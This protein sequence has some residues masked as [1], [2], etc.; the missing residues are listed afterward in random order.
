MTIRGIIDRFASAGGRGSRL[1][2]LCTVAFAGIMSQPR[3]SLA[4][5]WP[6]KTKPLFGGRIL[7]G[8][9]ANWLLTSMVYGYIIWTTVLMFG[10]CRASILLVAVCGRGGSRWRFWVLLRGGG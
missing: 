6:S 2:G 3:K 10:T 4:E 9:P 1:W 5:V 8:P 7:L